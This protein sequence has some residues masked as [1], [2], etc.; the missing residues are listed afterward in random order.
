M[1][2][3]CLLLSLGPQYMPHLPTCVVT[4]RKL[5][6]E[7]PDLNRVLIWSIFFP[8]N[9]PEFDAYASFPH[10]CMFHVKG[11]NPYSSVLN[12][13]PREVMRIKREIL[14]LQANLNFLLEE[15]NSGSFQRRGILWRPG[16]LDSFLQN[17]VVVQADKDASQV[18]MSVDCYC[19]EQELKMQTRHTTGEM[20]YERL[21]PL[22]RDMSDIWITQGK[23]WSRVIRDFFNELS[24]MFDENFQK[25]ISDYMY[26]LPP[27]R[28]PM[29]YLSAK[30]INHV[31]WCGVHGPADPSLHYKAGSTLGPQPCCPC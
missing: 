4:R 13:I 5:S 9:P 30:H 21:A 6:V 11:T 10:P 29:F 2:Y 28:M 22:S 23:Q 17:N 19:S 26:L 15:V 3:I 31:K 8:K 16:L 24:G 27:L 1:P 18:V 12:A 20:V 25:I 7:C 14:K